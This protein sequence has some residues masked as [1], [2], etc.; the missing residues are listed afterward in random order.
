MILTTLASA[1]NHLHFDSLG[2]KP[3]ALSLGFFDIKWYSLAYIS[4]ILL[5]WWYLLR[6]IAQPGSPMARRHAD[7]LVFYATLG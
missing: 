1:Q 6:L 4:G 7:D 5:G 2:L 3:V